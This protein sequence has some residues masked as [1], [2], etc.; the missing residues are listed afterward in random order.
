MPLPSIISP[1]RKGLRN[2]KLE[3]MSTMKNAVKKSPQRKFELTDETHQFYGTKL[4]RIRAVR[5]FGTVKAG[6]LGGFVEKE[7]NLSQKGKCWIADDA[8]VYDDAIV[9]GDALVKDRARVFYNARVGGK[10]RVVGKAALGGDAVVTGSG[11]V[12]ELP[13]AA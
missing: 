3:V 12:V 5:N 8:K 13:R 9:E 1:L 7:E 4:R 11:R 2:Q 10:V 6:A